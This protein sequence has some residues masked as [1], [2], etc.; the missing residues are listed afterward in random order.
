MQV[1][2]G[3]GAGSS[4]HC[5]PVACSSSHSQGQHPPVMLPATKRPRLTL[6]G[7]G[8]GSSGDLPDD[9][10]DQTL[11]ISHSSGGNR[12]LTDSVHEARSMLRRMQ[13]MEDLYDLTLR[14]R[15][16]SG[17]WTRLRAHRLV[18]AAASDQLRAMLL[19]AFREGRE[20]EVTFE[21]VPA[22]AARLLLDYIY[23]AHA[24]VQ[25]DRLLQ[26]AS[27]ADFF[28]LAEL[29]NTCVARAVQRLRPDNAAD[30]LVHADRQG[31]G[32]LK[33][34]CL[35]MILF[36]YSK[37]VQ[38]PG[39]V[40]LSCSLIEEL[41]RSDDLRVRREEETFESLVRWIKAESTRGLTEVETLLA[42]I[43][44]PRMS[45]QYLVVRVEQEPVVQGCLCLAN[46]LHEAKNHMLLTLCAAPNP[47]SAAWLLQP[48]S[49]RCRPRVEFGDVLV[50]GPQPGEPQ[51]DC[52]G[53][54]E[55]QDK[56][57]NGR[58]VYQQQGETDL[59]LYFANS[60]KWYIS[61]GEDMRLGK[62]RGWCQV[63]SHA[64]SPEKISED[65]TV[66]DPVTRMWE[67]DP[68]LKARQVNDAI[69]RELAA[70]QQ[71]QEAESRRQAQQVG[72]IVIE[73]QLPGDLQHDCMGIYELQEQAVNGRPVYRQQGGADMYLFYASR[74]SKWCISDGED[75]WAGRPKGWCYV[76]SQALTPDQIAEQWEVVAD[77]GG[78]DAYWRPAP[79]F[80]ARPRGKHF[81]RLLPASS[82]ESPAHREQSHT[83]MTPLR[84][85]TP[86]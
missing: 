36:D 68:R 34:K 21:E 16:E 54:Y 86:P 60:D 51:A 80:K 42:Y 25:R 39:F 56:V 8:R 59:F 76:V 67:Q 27:V 31:L 64:L 82:A 85:R 3:L 40:R 15:D 58:P 55:L 12:L 10:G 29:R 81:S 84:P 53:V 24:V 18:L 63:Q 83:E 5:P 11:S 48:E 23:T 52:M 7:G 43:R 19:G 45:P 57:V 74:G 49:P 4:Q 66:W 17:E 47:S 78:K 65:W 28:G 62:P 41:L 69:R 72:D 44:F 79:S 32:D 50:E 20:E 73:G 38:T 6:G 61:D 22:W 2:E 75:M 70:K 26:M 71:V 33:E 77:D 35:A 9:D 46:L 37:V 14:V 1:M 30:M 13:D